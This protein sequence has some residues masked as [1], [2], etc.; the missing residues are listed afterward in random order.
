M[1][2]NIAISLESLEHASLKVFEHASLEART[3][4][5]GRQS[6]LPGDTPAMRHHLQIPE[7]GRAL[8]H[9]ALTPR[10]LVRRNAT[11]RPILKGLRAMSNAITKSPARPTWT[12]PLN[13]QE[14]P[15]AAAHLDSMVDLKFERAPPWQL[16]LPLSILIWI[17]R[18]HGLL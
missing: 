15:F 10:F 17:G 9:R 3:H 16:L 12:E 5:G 8:K 6:A 13:D 7:N 11:Q 1:K 18:W 14:I 4:L 2:R